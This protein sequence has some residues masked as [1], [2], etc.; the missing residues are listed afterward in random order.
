MDIRSVEMFLRVL[1]QGSVTGAARSLGITQPAV[2]SAMAKLTADL[3]FDLFRRDG[4]TLVPTAEAREFEQE[5][6]RALMGLIQLE[7]AASGICSARRG[8]LTVA[9][10]P[11]AGIAWLPG[12]VA[13]FRATRPEVTLRLLTRS[14]L[15]VRALVAASGADV[16]IAQPPFDRGDSVL[17]RFRCSPV[18]VLPKAHALAAQPC[19]TPALLDGENFIALSRDLTPRM[20]I[21]DAFEAAGAICHVVVECEFFA[22]AMN[23][24]AAGVGV[25]ISEPVTARAMAGPDVVLR[26]FLPTLTYELALLSPPR[27]GLTRL[28]AAFKDAFTAH[29]APL[30]GDACRTPSE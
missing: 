9:A 29:V 7:E 25:T 20:A 28:A 10:S 3:G 6:R 22:T 19:I 5:A 17:Q 8:T 2:S 26:P 13:R 11:G 24:V 18:C 14:S 4:R 12:A 23:L 15:E 30:L 21:A 16:G 27:I 1:E